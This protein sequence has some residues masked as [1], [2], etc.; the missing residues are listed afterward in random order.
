[1]ISC[2]YCFYLFSLLLLQIYELFMKLPNNGRE[3]RNEKTGRHTLSCIIDRVY[4]DYFSVTESYLTRI[5]FPLW[6]S[7][8]L[9][10]GATRCPNTL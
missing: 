3:K 2:I 5:F 10:V 4:E 6:I 9:V 8:P 7:N 1:M